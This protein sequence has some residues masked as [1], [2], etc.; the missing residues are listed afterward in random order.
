MDQANFT[1]TPNIK[2]IGVGGG[3]NN[4]IN[5]LKESGHCP[6]VMMY[7]LNTDEQALR[8]CKADVTLPIGKT[9]TRGLGAGSDPEVGRR[10]AEESR[11]E[12][13][14]ILENTDIVFVASGMGGGT[15]TGA[16]PEVAKYARD[17]G[18]LTFAISTTPFVFEGAMRFHLALDGVKKLKANSDVCL[19]ISNQNLIESHGD[20]YVEESFSLPDSVMETTISGLIELLTAH[21][22]YG[23]N[24]DL[25]H[26]YNTLQN[27]GLALVSQA[28]VSD[29]E[30]SSA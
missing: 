18:I 24:L 10:A 22:Q 12:I 30:K 9:I 6:D 16:A 15:G 21:S 1:K 29:R 25:N 5:F 14:K 20:V 7:A 13:E 4:T 27:A 23:R 2:V 3:G 19:I 26:L 11:E 8:N 17:K 28:K